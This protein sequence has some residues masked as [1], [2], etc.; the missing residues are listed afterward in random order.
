MPDLALSLAFVT[1]LY[2]VFV[3]Q[4]YRKLF[5]DADTGWH[6]RTGERILRGEGL[7]HADPY[8]FSRPGAPWVAWEWASDVA[9]GFAHRMSGLRGV[10]ALY[11]AAIAASVW[12]WFRLHWA[13]EGNFLLACAML[14]PMLSTA[15]LH[16]LARPHVFSWLFLLG[17]VWIAES[18]LCRLRWFHFAGCGFLFAAWANIHASFPLGILLLAVYGIERKAMFGLAAAGAVG[19]LANPMGW[20]L[21]RHVF[22]YL[23]DRELLDRI[24]EFQSFNFHVD[25]AG[26]ILLTLLLTFAGAAAAVA[27]RHWSRALALALLAA[28]ALRSARGLPVLAMLALPLVNGSL[29][30]VL[31]SFH[32]WA[33][34]IGQYGRNLRALD[35]QMSGFVWSPLMLVILLAAFSSPA[36]VAQTGFDPA[37][38]P[39]AAARELDKVSGNVRLLSTDKFGGYLIY[40]FDGR[41][42]VFADGRSDFYGAAFLKRYLR[43]IEARPGWREMIDEFQITHALLPSD[44]PLRTVLELAG[45]TLLHQDSTAVLLARPAGPK[46]AV[47][48][49]ARCLWTVSAS[50]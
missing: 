22:A 25:G 42:K 30:S 39:V 11:I 23:T 21:H 3:F 9:M 33:D 6:I 37:D 29:S 46:A 35:R 34:K 17:I 28:F 31:P 7:P 44:G 14:P 38:F 26:Q 1:L 18:R 2:T 24:A 47:F 32:R 49:D 19:T 16:W 10:A 13:V 45:W 48:P 36:I 50:C 43:L 4:G 12:M 15:S 40:A 27:R 20:A 8:S 41:R 5:R